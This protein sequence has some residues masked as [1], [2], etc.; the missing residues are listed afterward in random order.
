MPSTRDNIAVYFTGLLYIDKL[1]L[2]TIPK[3][4]CRSATPGA[5]ALGVAA[6][7]CS[8]EINFHPTALK[9]IDPGISKMSNDGYYWKLLIMDFPVLHRI[10]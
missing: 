4:L 10:N 6:R 5:T 1:K 8:Y 3:L 9:D 7:S 2:A